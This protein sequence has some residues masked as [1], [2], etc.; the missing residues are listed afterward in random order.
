VNKIV[1]IVEHKVIRKLLYIFFLLSYKLNLKIFV[2]LFFYMYISIKKYY[3]IFILKNNK[4]N[5]T[6]ITFWRQSFLKDQVEL[7]KS[8][9]V[10]LIMIKPYVWSTL[11]KIFYPK[12]M[13]GQIKYHLFV[14][15]DS[16]KIKKKAE[17]FIFPILR[18]LNK[19]QLAD[20]FI[21]GN[22]D[23][24]EHQSWGD[25][26]KKLNIPFLV[27]LCEGYF[28]KYWHNRFINQEH[29]L[30]ET[31]FIYDKVLVPGTSAINLAEEANIASEDDII[32]TGY[33]R[34]DTTY[35]IF[36]KIKK[37]S[38]NEK[39]IILLIAFNEPNYL[40]D[41]LWTSVLDEFCNLAKNNKDFTFI[42]KT[43]KPT[44]T[45]SLLDSMDKNQKNITNLKVDDSFD[46]FEITEKLR[47]VIS[48]TSTFLLEAM[49]G[50]LPLIVPMWSDG[51]ESYK[52]GAT[53][54]DLN[55]S[56]LDYIYSVQDF[57][58]LIN[59]LCLQNKYEDY[60]INIEQN[61]NARKNFLKP[62]LYKVDGQRTKAITNHIIELTK[63]AL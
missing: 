49:C 6:V 12:Y 45:S 29:F 19:K 3:K 10:N 57:N 11:T 48:F 9:D 23:Y 25:A 44:L 52:A 17:Q 13:R 56:G 28:T 15:I 14:D 21:V 54:F 34:T 32:V 33:P 46:I 40:A 20:S 27:M 63:Q 55:N 8:K 42:I 53:F 59:D 60:L 1:E 62:F 50:K 35:A 43:K 18:Q 51:I 36:N 26:A 58:T 38:S 2:F 30:A 37:V 31:K 5:I 7:N 41:N 24:M 47:V 61:L 16:I 4:N 22:V 39:N